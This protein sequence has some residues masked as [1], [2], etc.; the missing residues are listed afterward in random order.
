[1]APHNIQDEGPADLENE[2][3]GT[4]VR[5]PTPPPLSAKPPRILIIGAGSR[6]RVYGRCTL[7]SSNGVIATVCEPDIYKR[8]DY[9]RT[10]IWS[11]AKHPAP[12]GSSFADWREF[13]EWEVQR[14]QREA[15]GENVPEGVDAAFV[16][17]RDEMHH[18]VVVA[19]A[20]LDLHIMCEKPLATTLD[21]CV[22]IYRAVAPLQPTKV[23]SVGHVLRYSPHNMLLRKLLLEDRAIGE[24]LSVVHT[25]PVGFWHFAHSYVRGNWRKESTTAPSLL[26]KSCHD[27][28]IILWLLCSPTHPESDAAPH[29]PSEVSSTGSLQ[30]FKRSRKPKA[31][32]DATNCLSCAAEPSCMY[33]SKRVYESQRHQGL[34]TGNIR[35]PMSVVLPDIESFGGDIEAARP[36]L[37]QTLGEDYTS[38][39]PQAEIDARN[40]FGRCVFESD[41]DVCD[42]QTV[43]I[44]WDEEPL[45]AEQDAYA[46]SVGHRGAKQAT[47]HMIAQTKRQCHRF[48]YIYGTTG[49]IYADSRTITIEDFRT[50]AQTSYHPKLESLG[51]GGGDHGITRNFI[52]A[53]DR[54]KNH[55]WAA[56]RAQRE[57]IGC[58]LEEII[59]SHAMVFAAEEARV[60]RKYVDWRS[61]WDEK[62]GAI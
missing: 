26:T 23:F 28:D 62:V 31:A 57:F 61:W 52:L 50:G 60:G 14:R 9:V 53:V 16:C 36:K 56:P 43:T 54:V 15:A 4:E 19:L 18:D 22:G 29:I 32:G 42:E 45:S 33:S 2:P 24:I 48:T 17:V 25:E 39:T 58:S 51:H 21:D 27:I 1:M 11:D 12:E 35:W 47:F 8:Q 7:Q 3:A 49:E 20:P 13:I 37:L 46:D 34:E 44:K 6:G 30:F 38:T 41:N 10:F 55:G 5:P 40:W 59:R